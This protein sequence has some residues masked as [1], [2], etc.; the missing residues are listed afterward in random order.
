[1]PAYIGHIE[2]FLNENGHWS[3]RW[4]P[5]HYDELGPTDQRVRPTLEEAL[6]AIQEAVLSRTETEKGTKTLPNLRPPPPAPQVPRGD[7]HEEMARLVWATAFATA[8]ERSSDEL[9]ASRSAESA[10]RAYKRLRS[11]TK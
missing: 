4:T 7:P 10:V 11:L 1:M 6:E 5:Q 8:H 3:A 9:D 2:V